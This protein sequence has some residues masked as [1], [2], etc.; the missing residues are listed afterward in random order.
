[1]VSHAVVLVRCSG[2]HNKKAGVAMRFIH[3]ADWQVGMKARQVSVAA[4]RVRQER[5]AAAQRVVDEANS[6]KADF[7]LIAG[8][9]FEDNAIGGAQVQRTADI[10]SGFDGPVYLIPGN[11]DPLVPGSVWEHASWT[12]CRNIHIL[13]APEPVAVPEGTL[14]PCPVYE[15]ISRREPTDWIRAEGP[16]IRIGMAHGT[17]AGISTDEPDYPVSRDAATRAGLD[18]LALGHWHSY[19]PY[20]DSA[21]AVRMA[22]SGSH[23][24]T[25]FG[26]RDS[27]NV[28]LVEVGAPGDPPQVTPLKTGKL[29]WI[30]LEREILGSED[31]TAVRKEVEQLPEAES[32]L[33]ELHLFGTIDVNGLEEIERLEEIV[34]ARLLFHRLELSRLRPSPADDSWLAGLPPGIIRDAAERIRELCDPGYSGQR[35]E[36]A[37]AE[38][39]SQALLRLY[40]LMEE[41]HR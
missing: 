22:Y 15:R 40:S 5:F 14:Y 39:A 1:M 31:L 26:E 29:R 10:L 13:R 8:D 21:G 12:D 23:E 9:T 16:D 6:H 17:V 27:G 24:P 2:L 7:I 36:G 37:T 11:H 33:L 20:T 19:T 38:V 34:E 41:A 30:Q 35:P 32:T 25:K 18:Y 28:L 4:E 3:T